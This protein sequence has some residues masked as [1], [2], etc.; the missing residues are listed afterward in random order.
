MLTH[1]KSEAMA[2]YHLAL[3]LFY[4]ETPK[5]C[6][7]FTLMSGIKSSVSDI[8]HQSRMKFYSQFG[9]YP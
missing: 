5:G 1:M 6:M 4:K 7:Y 8:D 2:S 9:S 3:S